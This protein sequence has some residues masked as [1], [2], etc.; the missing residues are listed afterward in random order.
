LRGGPQ[1][2]EHGHSRT[3]GRRRH[4]RVPVPAEQTAGVDAGRCEK[5]TILIWYVTY[6]PARIGRV[7]EKTIIFCI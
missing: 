4:Q 5:T 3:A 7:V 6:N 1:K 2:P